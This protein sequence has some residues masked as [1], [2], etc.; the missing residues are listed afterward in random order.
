MSL[1]WGIS[2]CQHLYVFLS[3]MFDVILNL[4]SLVHIV[5]EQ[6]HPGDAKKMQMAWAHWPEFAS[7]YQIQLAGWPAEIGN[8]GPGFNHKLDLKSKVLAKLIFA[9][10]QALSHDEGDDGAVYEGLL[11]HIEPWTDGMW[12][13]DKFY[14]VLSHLLH[15]GERTTQ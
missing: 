9:C 8:P 13:I 14:V 2:A 6:V 11:C 15:R 7:H 10:I 5:H 12:F 4:S 3:Q 1:I